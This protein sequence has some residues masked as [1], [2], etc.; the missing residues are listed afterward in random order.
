MNEWIGAAIAIGAGFI[1]GVFVAAVVRRALGA[2]SRAEILQRLAEPLA[3]VA[4]WLA[5][6]VGL[7]VALGIVNPDSL[8]T[9]PKDAVDYLPRLIAGLIVFIVGNAAAGLA[10][11]A[12]AAALARAAASAQRIV[13]S[14]VRAAILVMT[15]IIAAGQIGLDTTIVN[16]AVAAM[17][18]SLGLAA[19]LLV[20]LG[21]RE[22]SGEVAAARALRSMMNA[23]DVVDV[24]KWSGR[25]VAVHS[26]AV[27]LESGGQIHLVPNSM[28]LLNTVRIE[29]AESEEDD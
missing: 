22:V 2:E 26:T 9:L 7:I 10:A 19:A 4:F 23:G 14:A 12:V 25:V 3:N 6:V 8:E 17:L 18:F 15:V 5:V 27:E 29:R 21:G 20:G 24:D 16:L 13:P 11:S 28:F 1:V